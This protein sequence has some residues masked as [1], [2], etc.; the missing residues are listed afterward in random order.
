MNNTNLKSPGIELESEE[1]VPENNEIPKSLSAFATL[2][3][4]NI[5]VMKKLNQIYFYSF[6]I[7]NSPF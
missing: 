7:I 6:F 2:T 3:D 4:N 5:M 1:L